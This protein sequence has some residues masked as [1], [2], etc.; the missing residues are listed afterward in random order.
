MLWIDWYFKIMAI[1]HRLTTLAVIMTSMVTGE[2]WLAE[3]GG[4]LVTSW[5]LERRGCRGWWLLGMVTTWM[6]HHNLETRWFL[7][8]FLLVTAS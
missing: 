6:L 4:G 8:V 7:N 1:Q 5:M 2:S 3:L